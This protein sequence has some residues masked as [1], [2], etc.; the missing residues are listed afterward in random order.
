MLIGEYKL[1]PVGYTN[2]FLRIFPSHIL[3][4]HVLSSSNGCRSQGACEFAMVVVES[5]L[6]RDSFQ[7]GFPDDRNS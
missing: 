4:D 5:L 1:L 7:K 3:D 2:K 6:L